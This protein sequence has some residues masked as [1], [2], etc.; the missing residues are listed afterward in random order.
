MGAQVL[1]IAQRYRAD[2]VIMHVFGR[3][4]SVAIKT[5]K[6]SG[7]PLSKVLGFVWASSE[8]DIKAAGGMGSGA[9]LQHDAVRRRG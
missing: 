6:Q 8:A 1:D 4:P 7:Y 5:L 9:G 2:F 3:A